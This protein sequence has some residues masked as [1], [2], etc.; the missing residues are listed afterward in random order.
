MPANQNSKI[1]KVQ[2]ETYMRFSNYRGFNFHR[3]E[4]DQRS[5]TITLKKGTYEVTESDSE[6]TITLINKKVRKCV[7]REF[8]ACYDGKIYIDDKEQENRN[9][10]HLLAIDYLYGLFN[11]LVG[12]RILKV[13]Q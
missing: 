11:R 5:A 1:K 6:I 9:G 7:R 2:A 3:G 12:Y 13:Q 4:P 10:T 8:V